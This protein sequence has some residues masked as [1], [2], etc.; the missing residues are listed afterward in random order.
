M[1]H[2]EV[3]GMSMCE[4]LHHESKQSLQPHNKQWKQAGVSLIE[5]MVVVSVMG[6]LMMF[7]VPFYNDY[8]ATAEISA[9]NNNMTTIILFEEEARMSTGAYVEG[10]Y[11]PAD[12]DNADGLKIKIGWDP[13]SSVDGVTYVVSAASA[14]GFTLSAKD[15]GG[16]EV[17]SRTYTR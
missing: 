12:P 4:D 2:V 3:G 16:A 10:E 15:S 5:L 14:N 11:D 6:I 8:I 7:S 9:I 13:R 1:K 17:H